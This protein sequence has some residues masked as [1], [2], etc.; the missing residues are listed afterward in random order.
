MELFEGLG[1]RVGADD[2][3]QKIGGEVT[4][5]RDHVIGQLVD[6]HHL[7]DGVVD[8]RVG[9][10]AGFDAERHVL[11]DAQEPVADVN[12]RMWEQLTAISRRKM[13]DPPSWS[14]SMPLF[15]KI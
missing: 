10:A 4:R 8:R 5:R 3:K 2:A 11:D 1:H 15:S 13:T 14:K 12:A 7:A 9:V 6:A